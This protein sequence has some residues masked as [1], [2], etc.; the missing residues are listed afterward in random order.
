MARPMPLEAPVTMAVFPVSALVVDMRS[1]LDGVPDTCVQ[2]SQ[3]V[4]WHRRR[5]LDTRAAARHIRSV[6]IFLVRHGETIGN[7]ARIVQLPDAPLSPAGI[8]Q[9]DALARRLASA[10]IVRI[11]TSDLMRARTTAAALA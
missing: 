6:A 3:R 2:W 9:A 8:L 4:T 1:S 5:R 11:R 10:G 7:A